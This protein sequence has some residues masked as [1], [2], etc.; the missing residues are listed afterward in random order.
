[1][2]N[3]TCTIPFCIATAIRYNFKDKWEEVL[4][5]I[6][7]CIFQFL[8]Q[9]APSKGSSLS[10]SQRPSDNLQMQMA[11]GAWVVGGILT[12]TRLPL[13]AC[14]IIVFLAASSCLAIPQRLYIDGWRYL[15]LPWIFGDASTLITVCMVVSYG[16]TGHTGYSGVHC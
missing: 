3:E 12:R 16:N 8:Y 6:Q 9:K 1:M 11:T 5:G 2:S 13:Y 4:S 10:Y 15:L 7:L 14:I